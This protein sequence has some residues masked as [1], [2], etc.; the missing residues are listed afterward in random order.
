M[1]RKGNIVRANLEADNDF[2]PRIITKTMKVRDD[3][4]G[5]ETWGVKPD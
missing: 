2:T 3:T 1:P 4:N 5:P